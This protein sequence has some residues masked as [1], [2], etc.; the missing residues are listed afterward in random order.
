MQKRPWLEQR[1]MSRVKPQVQ[2]E[3][4]V[5]ANIPVL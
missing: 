1:E 4:V 3:A 2:K 5:A